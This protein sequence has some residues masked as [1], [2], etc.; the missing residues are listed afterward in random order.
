MGRPERRGARRARRSDDR[1]HHAHDQDL[2]IQGIRDQIDLAKKNAVSIQ[3]HIDSILEAT[4]D[5]SGRKQ[6]QELRAKAKE[7]KARLKSWIQAAEVGFKIDADPRKLAE[8]G[9]K[10]LGVLIERF[11]KP[12]FDIEADKLEGILDVKRI[13]SLKDDQ[14]QAKTDQADAQAA[15]ERAQSLATQLHES[16]E[17]W[18]KLAGEDFDSDDSA[19]GLFNFAELTV[20]LAKAD[21]IV[22]TWAPD[23]RRAA[24]AAAI[25]ISGYL[26]KASIAKNEEPGPTLHAMADEAYRWHVQAEA[27][28]KQADSLRQQLGNARDAALAA[29]RSMT[30]R[31]KTRTKKKRSR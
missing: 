29:L 22:S 21:D 8:A 1:S 24:D 9:V 28:S 5:F 30:P 2:A 10:L 23:M 4:E 12:I 26:K 17:N 15:I 16:A 20:P 25:A 27:V 7:E 31:A 19:E 6:V 18:R 3:R 14:S 13:K 11:H